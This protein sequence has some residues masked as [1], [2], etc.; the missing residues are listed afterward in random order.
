MKIDIK[1]IEILVSPIAYWQHF[2]MACPQQL[3][4]KGS[5][6]PDT[7]HEITKVRVM[8]IVER[9]LPSYLIYTINI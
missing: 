5:A 4:I 7:S 3:I 6:N 2:G 9:L 8:V 1:S